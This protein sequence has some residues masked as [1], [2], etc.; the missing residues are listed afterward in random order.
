MSPAS[1]NPFAN[2]PDRFAIWEILM[3][4]DF[5]A[6]VAADW[7]L[8]ADDFMADEFYGVDAGKVGDPDHWKL[9]FPDLAA[10]RAEWMKQAVEFK[11]VGLEGANK[12][13]FLFSSIALQRIEIEG[14]RSLAR[15]KFSG[16]VISTT[17]QPV[18]LL[19]QTLYFLRKDE[20][21]WKITGFVGYLPPS[22][23]RCYA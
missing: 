17:G 5:E 13:D 23:A 7:S 16:R 18:Q 8:I 19:W 9:R 10:Y 21:Q 2:D 20:T 4:R 6:F 11:S 22:A 15:K 3:R 14:T 1:H 12:L